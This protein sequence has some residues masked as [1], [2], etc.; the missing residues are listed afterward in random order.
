MTTDL[1]WKAG[2]D[3]ATPRGIG[4]LCNFYAERAEDA[5]IWD[6]DGKRFIDF[7]AGIAALNV[8]HR[9]PKIVAAVSEQL[10]RCT[11]TAYQVVPYGSYVQLAKIFELPT[12]YER[13]I[14]RFQY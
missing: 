13:Y 2:K 8:S 14:Q 6:V 7:A 9:H 4:M 1:E 3:A 5:A 10:M 11:L 12:N